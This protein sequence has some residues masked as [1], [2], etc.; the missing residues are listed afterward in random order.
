MGS[1]RH[2]SYP[3]IS[4]ASVLMRGPR[5]S[6][7]STSRR[8]ATS[9]T[10]PPTPRM[11]VITALAL[12]D[13]RGQRVRRL[14]A[15]AADRPDHQRVF[16][17]R[18]DTD[19]VAPGAVHHTPVLVLLAPGRGRAGHRPDGALRL[20]EDPRA[21]HAGG[22]RGDPHGRQQGRS[23]GSRVLKPVSAAIA[24][25]TGGP[26]GAEGPIIMTG[27][28]IGSLF[29]QSLHLTADERKTLL[30]A[31]AAAGM[32]ATFNAPLASMLLAVELLL[33]E[34]RP[35]SL[36]A[37]RRRGRRR[38]R[39]AR[40]RCSAPARSSRPSARCTST[41]STYALCVVAG[42]VA[43]PARARRDRAG[44]R[45]RGRL[46]PAADPLDVVAGHRR[47]SSSA[48][49]ACSCRRRSASATTSSAPSSPA[50]SASAWSSASSWSRR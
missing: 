50:R 23:R 36:R 8:R 7:N 10:S 34:W 5:T 39:R 44:L 48:S 2:M 31:G 3:D 19:L 27:G 40:R 11:L 4:E 38:D 42:V 9:A 47:R 33:F 21:R 13:R 12:P 41:T 37:G 32:A 25:G 24:I 30:V 15:A 29:A 46:P 14:G 20:R 18:F 17:Q 43:G 45:L 26:F 28:A 35:R 22:D 1:I 16:Y 49:A 6:A